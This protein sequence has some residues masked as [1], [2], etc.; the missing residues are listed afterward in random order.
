MQNLSTSNTEIQKNSKIE[1][2]NARKIAKSKQINQKI[3][4]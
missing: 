3:L 4:V 2:Q 1:K